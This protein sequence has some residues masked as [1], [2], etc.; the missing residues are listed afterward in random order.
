IG[1][2]IGYTIAICIIAAIREIFGTG[3]ITFGETFTF[4]AAANGGNP[5][6]LYMLTGPSADPVSGPAW[7]FSMSFFTNPAGAFLVLGIVLAVI[8][9]F[10]NSKAEKAKVDA[11]LEASA[12]RKAAAA[13]AAPKPAAQATAASAKPAQPAAKPAAP[14][15]GE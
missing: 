15:G 8:A 1:N 2:G 5:I 12:A 7:D 14:K 10:R 6:H 13:S 11:R 9:A 4:L 3:M